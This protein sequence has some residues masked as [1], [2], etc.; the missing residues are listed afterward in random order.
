MLNITFLVFNIW[1]KGTYWRAYNIARKLCERGHS[2]NLYCTAQ[3]SKFLI[4]KYVSEGVT[5]I[6]VPDLLHGVLRSGWDPWNT[7][8]RILD[9]RTV[10]MDLVHI[11]ET[12]PVNIYP[13]LFLKYKNYPL[14]ID[15]CDY[16]SAGGSV[17]QRKNWL[18][19]QL[20]RPIETY[21]ENRFRNIAD[22]TTVINRF[23][24]E[25]ALSLGVKK[26][27]LKI[28]RNGCDISQQP[29]F[30]NE[31]RKMLGFSLTDKIIGY[32][33]SAFY[34]D[35]RLMIDGFNIIARKIPNV[36]LLLIGY[37]NWDFSK[38]KLPSE[39][40]G[41]VIKTGTISYHDVF[42]YIALCDV[43][44]L[45]LTNTLANLGRTPLKF[46]DYLTMGK[47]IVTTDVGE[48]GEY[49]R[50]FE[51][52]FVSKDT[53]ELFAVN[54]MTLLSDPQLCTRFGIKARE[55][56]EK[57]FDWNLIAENVE[58]FYYSMLSQSR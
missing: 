58:E 24:F 30:K 18:L 35:A 22:G 19:R 27:K 3:T 17:E 7:I 56:A 28:I 37:F 45:P 23:L 46:N 14:F 4:K 36:K 55:V 6:E 44:W 39:I 49:I 47:P 50:N 25:R 38:L 15:W 5:I 9:L 29:I 16:F 10:R 40:T 33:G 26:S 8:R 32:T 21:Y 43:C 1:G 31:A 2:V 42:K 51:I 48:I 53:P 20:L 41:K 52:G 54:T 57:Y 34:S 12:R 11:F 13:G